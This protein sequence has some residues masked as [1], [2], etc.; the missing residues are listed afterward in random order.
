M[1][2]ITCINYEQHYLWS[3][4]PSKKYCC[5]PPQNLE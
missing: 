4:N 3:L 5:P 2:N 1:Q